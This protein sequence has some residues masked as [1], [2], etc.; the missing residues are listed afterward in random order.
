MT[1]RQRVLAVLHGKKA[2]RVP[3]FG[4]LDYWASS[5][6]ASGKKQSDF[7]RREHYIDWHRELGVGFYLQGYFPFKT[8]VE[9]CKCSE[10]KE[11]NRRYRRIET[12]KGILRECWTYIPEAFTEAPTEHLLKSRSDL[13][14]YRYMHEN[15]RYEPDYDF[16]FERIAQVG[17][18]GILLCYL[19]KSPLMQM[20]A[21]DA[22]IMAVTMM[23]FDEPDEFSQTLAVVRKSHDTAAEIALKSPAEALM[24]PENLSSEVVGPKFFES[25]MRDYHTRW[26]HNINT[27]GK[28]SFVHL[29]GT[30]KGLL[31]LEAQTGIKV[32]EAMTPSPV[33]DLAVSRWSD[34]VQ[35]DDTVLWGGIPGVYFTSHTPENEFERHV[36]ETLNIMKQQPRYV[37]G[38]AD[39]VPPDGI[40]G[41]VRRV[42]ELV[43]KYGAYC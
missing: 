24:I 8:I 11:G 12:P 10:W 32:I 15:T 21:L 41:R 3:W 9:N 7:V 29:D 2:D 28:Y 14:A 5:L 39:Q 6:A 36:I 20:V 33:G 22:G 25:Y 42:G 16:A 18:M 34:E 35:N 40:E 31:R 26:A 37:L 30:L 38:V 27:A 4:D 19:P 1:P 23:N 17:D 43:E 13:A